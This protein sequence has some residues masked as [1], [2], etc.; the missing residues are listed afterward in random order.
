VD[1]KVVQ[2]APVV[3]GPVELSHDECARRCARGQER[4]AQL[5][6]QIADLTAE[7]TALEAQ[8]AILAHGCADDADKP[9]KGRN[10]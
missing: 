7:K 2:P 5:A 3:T 9:G 1:G 10:R 4:V 6:K 8:L